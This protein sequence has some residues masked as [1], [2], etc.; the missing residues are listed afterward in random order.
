MIWIYL[1][2]G[3]DAFILVLFIFCALKLNQQEE[4][5]ISHHR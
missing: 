2:L 1:F 3:I 4:E 5:K